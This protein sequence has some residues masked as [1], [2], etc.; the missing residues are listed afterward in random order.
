MTALEE[1]P[2]N[3]PSPSEVRAALS[4][5]VVAALGRLSEP[6]PELADAVRTQRRA[7]A[8][9]FD[10]VAEV[11][12]KG[13]WRGSYRSP[14]AWLAALTHESIGHCS[15]TIT[16][17]T[18]LPE[19]PKVR[20]ACRDGLLSDSA[21]RLLAEAWHADIANVFARDE[22]MLLGW[23]RD[24]PYRDF[25]IVIDTWRAHAHPERDEHA[26]EEQF[27]QRHLSVSGLL[28]GMGKLDG[29]LDPEG[30]AVVREALRALGQRADLDERTPGQ[31]RA[32]AL[33]G[34][35]KMALDQMGADAPSTGS[36]RT[37]PKVIAT[38]TIDDLERRAHGGT[39]DTNDHR[40]T[41]SADALR[42]LACD[43]GIHRY[44]TDPLGTVVDYGRQQRTVSD[45]QFDRLVVRDHG[46]RW[47]GCGFAAAGCDAHHAV[48]WLD[49]GETNDDNLALLCWF[50]H[51]LL[52]EQHWSMQPLGAGHFTL[53][54]P[55]GAT[56]PMRPPVVGL[57]L[58]ATP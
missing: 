1:P 42:R 29:V 31:R 22:E 46:C 16:I 8:T 54:D 57:A 52:H 20:A 7:R 37:R 45:T 53:I 3:T 33:V 44:L 12:T 18:H 55:Q 40:C 23:A 21:L 30:F 51:H 35:A 11:L 43:C 13:S 17:A 28:D 5:A 49:H 14:T 4:A 26:A 50:H 27:E 2:A 15:T 48:H 39:L 41:M 9:Q 25:K 19:M 10:E 6:Y 24:L 58:S 47:P 34:M 56:H 38:A 32:D 36:K